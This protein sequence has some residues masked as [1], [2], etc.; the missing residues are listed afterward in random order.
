M[1]VGDLKLEDAG[2]S[3]AMGIHNVDSPREIAD[4]IIN[5]SKKA[6]RPL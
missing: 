5:S 1:G 4:F 3:G 2:E 6:Q